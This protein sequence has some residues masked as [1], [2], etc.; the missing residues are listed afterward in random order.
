M[1]DD[2][3]GIDDIVDCSLSTN[4]DSGG[5]VTKKYE[6][7]GCEWGVRYEEGFVPRHMVSCAT[8]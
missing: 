2:A 6:L 5:A 4:W 3:V 1:K 8:V 7:G